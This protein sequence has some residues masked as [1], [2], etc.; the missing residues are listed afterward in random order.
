MPQFRNW[1]GDYQDRQD[2]RQYPGPVA[3]PAPAPAAAPAPGPMPDF[4]TFEMPSYGGASSPTYNFGQVPGFNAPR[5]S[6]PTFAQAQQDPGYQFR[7]D[8]GSQ[9]LNRSAAARGVLRTG[10]TLKDI[11]EYGQNFGAQEYK[12]VFD[13][14]MQAYGTK[15]QAAKDEYAPKFAQYNNQFSA[16]QA[17]AMAE[18]NRQY[19]LYQTQAQMQMAKEQ[20][21]NQNLQMQS[22]TFPTYGG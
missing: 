20:L 1:D 2:H 15:Y 14:A 18:F 17:R 6:A 21:I 11:T 4:G 8:A 7:L 9:A 19:E 5:F 10:G 3:A 12:S 22:P 13:R 16:E